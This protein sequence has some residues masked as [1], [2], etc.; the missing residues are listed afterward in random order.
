[1]TALTLAV[2]GIGWLINPAWLA[3][4]AMPIPAWIRWM[5]LA[6]AGLGGML[7]VWTFRNL[8]KNLTDTVVTRKQHTLVTTGPY[9][10][11][12]HPFYA[13]YLLGFVGCSVAAANWLFLLLGTIGFGFMLARI[14]IEEQK[15]V[16]RFG[17]AYRRYMARTGRF[18]PRIVRT[19]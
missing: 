11:I 12:R 5:G 7:L 15:L 17:D 6:M 4:A 2:G 9:R 18:V 3:W 10:W 1:L 8:D 13:S 16:E 19:G 14:R